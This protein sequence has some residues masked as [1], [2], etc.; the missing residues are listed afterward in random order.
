[1]QFHSVC[2]VNAKENQKEEKNGIPKKKRRLSGTNQLPD[3]SNDIENLMRITLSQKEKALK[4]LREE[5]VTRAKKLPKF[6]IQSPIEKF[7]KNSGF[8]DDSAEAVDDVEY[9][10]LSSFSNSQEPSDEE[11]NT[12]EKIRDD[13][14][15]RVENADTEVSGGRGLENAG[16]RREKEK[17]VN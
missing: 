2:H 6:A 5:I 11:V 3:V 7:L 8:L 13:M 16:Q 4:I 1:M 15:K 14:L 17:K 9:E 12:C 10:I